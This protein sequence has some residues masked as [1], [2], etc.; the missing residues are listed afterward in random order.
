MEYIVPFLLVLALVVVPTAFCLRR[1]RKS[2]LRMEDGAGVVRYVF[3]LASNREVLYTNYYDFNP[4]VERPSYNL[5]GNV[6][7]CKNACEAGRC[8]TSRKCAYCALRQGI[9]NAF[10]MKKGFND[11]FT[12]MRFN[13]AHGHEYEAEVRA[14][15]IY[16][17][18]DDKPH[19]VL[20]V[21]VP[22]KD[23]LK[24]S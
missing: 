10:S 3:G 6:L 7:R 14:N 16:M 23:N 18:R 11:L 9:I 1:G 20:E 15:A 5:L 12:E 17:V 22:K 2:V 8:G 21:Q 19:L 13:S 4:A 24:E